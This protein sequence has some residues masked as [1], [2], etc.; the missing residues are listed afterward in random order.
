MGAICIS[1]SP[2]EIDKEKADAM[3]LKAG[4]FVVLTVTDT[5]MGMDDVTRARIF[6]PFFS[7]K[8]RTRGTG[9]GLASTYGIIKH[10]GGSIAVESEV[11]IG[12][13]FTIHLPATDKE[14]VSEPEITE[15]LLT[16]RETV[17]LIDDEDMI[18]DVGARMLAGLGYTVMTARS[19]REGLRLYDLHKDEID[20]VILDM[21]MPDLGGKETFEALLR[22]DP[23]VKV[24]LSSGFGIDGQAKEIMAAGCQGFIQKPFGMGD[25]SRMIRAVLDRHNP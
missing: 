19:G 13:T 12:T 23:G 22:Q 2:I 8:E 9:L 11:G 20:I 17:L 18:I 24:L 3:D 4:R 1:R 25:L 16:G 7:T 10:H 6:E 14:A 21:I 5:G 15:T